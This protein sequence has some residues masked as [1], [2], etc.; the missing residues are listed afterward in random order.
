MGSPVFYAKFYAD[1]HAKQNP[2]L[3]QLFLLQ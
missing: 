2:F 3:L 1:F